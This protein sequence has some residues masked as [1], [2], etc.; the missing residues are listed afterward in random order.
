MY[1]FFVSPENIAGDQVFLSGSDVKHISTVLRMKAGDKIHVLDGLGYLYDVKLAEIK[2]KEIIGDILSREK[3]QTESPLKIHMGQALIKGNKFDHV[4]RKSVELGVYSITC[5]STER[6]IPRLKNDEENSRINR[7]RKIAGEASKQCGRSQ[8]PQIDEAI[9]S[10]EQFCQRAK[11]CDLKLI[12]WESEETTRLKDLKS[13]RE[14]T[15]VA[16]IAG[17]EGGFPIGEVEM[18]VQFGFK[19]V[20]LGSRILKADSASLVI[21]SIL[22]SIWGDL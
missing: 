9:L 21:I 3:Y 19:S 13:A 1:R 20:S 15:S 10:M 11:D 2:R 18:A 6:C 5:L 17:P 14:I 12:F 22:Q 4:V 8:V 16:F 7:W